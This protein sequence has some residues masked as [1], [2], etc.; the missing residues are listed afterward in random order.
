MT[1]YLQ[2]FFQQLQAS[3]TWLILAL[4]AALLLANSHF[5]A[6]FNAILHQHWAIAKLD[7]SLQHWINDGLM[8]IFFLMVGLEIKREIVEGELSDPR[9]A[10]LPIFAALGGMLV[11]AIIYYISNVHGPFAQA[12]AIPTATDIAFSLAIVGL[13]GKRVPLSLKIFLTALAIVDDLGA[14]VIIALCYVQQINYL[15]LIYALL[16]LLMLVGFN[17]WQRRSLWWYLLPAPLLW[18]LVQQSGIHASIAGVLLAMCLPTNPS[19][20]IASPLEILE[21]SLHWP[22]SFLIMPIFALANTNIQFRAPMVDQLAQP[23]SMGIIGGLFLGKTLGINLM[24]WLSIRLKWAQL[25][26]GSRWQQMWGVGFLAGIGFTMAI[27]MA[28]MA[29]ADVQ[30]QDQAKFS[31]LLASL[32]SGVVGFMML[33][34]RSK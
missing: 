27:F 8:A 14:I 31:V 25:P 11:P 2:N 9:K 1:K 34:A 4:V 23:L 17:L 24:A 13:L 21:K 10:R 7:M 26:S 15:Y 12:W 19:K 18:F 29:I 33:K 3:S 6:D 30:A 22:V 28:T 32:L 16:V 5:S 20:T